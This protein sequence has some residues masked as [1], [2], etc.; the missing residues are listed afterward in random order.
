M[1]EDKREVQCQ[2]DR[3]SRTIRGQQAQRVAPPCAQRECTHS[4]PGRANQ[5]RHLGRGPRTGPGTPPASRRRRSPPGTQGHTRRTATPGPGPAAGPCGSVCW[6]GR[7]CRSPPPPPRCCRRTFLQQHWAP[8]P[9]LRCSSCL[10]CRPTAVSE[11]FFASG[12][13]GFPFLVAQAAEDNT[14]YVYH[15]YQAGSALRHARGPEPTPTAR[16][17]PRTTK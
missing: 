6:C 3:A 16:P 8:R 13:V 2:R 1:G 14:H 11:A 5:M 17:R 10:P 7:Q 9:L 4:G 15:Q 12:G